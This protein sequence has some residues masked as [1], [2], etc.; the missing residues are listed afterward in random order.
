MIARRAAVPA[1]PAD[2]AIEARV[3]QR[4]HAQRCLRVFA[5]GEFGELR[6]VLQNIPTENPKTGRL[7]AMSMIKALRNLTAAAV[8]LCVCCLW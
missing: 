5:R 8:R 3:R 4:L 2:E 1:H 7:T 6:I